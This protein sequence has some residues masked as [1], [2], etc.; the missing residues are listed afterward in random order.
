MKDSKIKLTKSAKTQTLELD[1]SIKVQNQFDKFKITHKYNYGKKNY[2]IMGFLDLT[3]SDFKISKLNYQ[4][5]LGKK[6][7][8][9][10]DAD[11]SLKKYYNINQ[12][13]FL[14]GENK[15]NL[16]NIKLNQKNLNG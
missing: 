12:L 13:K 8:L 15:V 4:K 7:E 11:F 14:A 1:G 16:E 6:A 2:N 10:F 5:N 3:N 9:S